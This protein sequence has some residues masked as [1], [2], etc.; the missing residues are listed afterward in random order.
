[1]D[2]ESFQDQI[3]RKLRN[4]E[5]NE[6]EVG[7]GQTQTEQEDQTQ[8]QDQDQTQTQ[9][10]NQQGTSG[11]QRGEEGNEEQP[12]AGTQKGRG[13]GKGKAVGLIRIK[14]LTQQQEQLKLAEE[15]ETA[16]QARLMVEKEAKE[17]AEKRIQTREAEEEGESEE[18]EEEGIWEAVGD[19][20]NSRKSVWNDRIVGGVVI[21]E[22]PASSNEPVVTTATN[23]LLQRMDKEI[24][25]VFTAHDQTRY[26]AL[27]E[28]Q[29]QWLE[30][31]EKK[32]GERENKGTSTEPTLKKQ[33]GPDGKMAD[34]RVRDKKYEKRAGRETLRRN[35]DT[36]RDN[37]YAFGA[38]KAMI[39]PVNG[40]SW[41][42]Q[43]G[44]WD[45]VGRGETSDTVDKVEVTKNT[46]SVRSTLWAQ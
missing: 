24:E 17:A 34:I 21:E 42:G 41:E 11:D 38:V 13:K 25:K 40:V 14:P 3:D 16:S 8:T 4:G 6:E 20:G 9:V 35:E 1:M 43:K 36:Y 45:D 19:N 29:R 7:E 26:D 37:P 23:R 31:K 15:K 22:N 39:D 28:E 30:F 46:Q 2:S 32:G 12:V 27:V 10:Q 18:D 5:G 44:T 33:V